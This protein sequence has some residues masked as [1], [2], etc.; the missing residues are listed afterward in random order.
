MVT[1]QI[2]TKIRSGVR[3][4][5]AELFHEQQQRIFAS[6]DRMFAVLLACQ[7][8]AAIGAALWI[9]PRAW[10]G[11]TSYVHP[12]VWTAVLL[13]AVI[14]SLPLALALLR[15]GQM[16]TRHTIA[17]A[18]MLTSAILIH[19]SGGRIETHFHIFGSLAFLAL[20][21]DWRVLITA[22]VVVAADHLV[23]GAFWPW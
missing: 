11:A 7:W 5:T 21:R 2:P 23:R 14:D 13:L 1:A 3:Q 10:E 17:I 19:L 8:L 22:S 18:Q 6:T 15:P 12:H 16:L 9:S 20:Y 4:R